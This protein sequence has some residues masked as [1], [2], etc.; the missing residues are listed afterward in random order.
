MT[1]HSIHIFDRKGATVF[2]KTFSVAATK[3]QQHL[4]QSGPSEPGV[5]PLDEQRKL[6]FGMLFSIRE[7]VGTLSPDN[8]SSALHSVRTGAATLH[9][10]E[11]LSGLRFA[12]YTSNNVP[13]SKGSATSNK[14][15]Y[16]ES[17]SARDALKYIYS[18]IYV[19]YV[20]RSPLYTSNNGN[21]N[22][23]STT[24]EKNLDVYLASLPWYR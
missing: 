7:I 11:T 13:S 5:S 17:I 22:V 19:E 4:L 24:F 18:N 2:T 12:L 1:V 23:G 15:E 6:V 10:Y 9:S 8:K 16:S 21:F 20:I 14:S 3:Q